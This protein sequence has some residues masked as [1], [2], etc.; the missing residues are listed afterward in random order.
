MLSINLDY[1]SNT[2]TVLHK[3]TTTIPEHYSL[4]IGAKMSYYT[5]NAK[6]TPRTHRTLENISGQDMLHSNV[7]LQRF[8]G[9]EFLIAYFFDQNKNPIQFDCS[10][11][12]ANAPS[13][14]PPFTSIRS[15]HIFRTRT[16]RPPDVCPEFAAS[17]L[18]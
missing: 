9:A 8:F 3:V 14:S 16:Y 18:C 11:E 10:T 5:A 7:Q 6:E 13:S 1:C 17:Q 12:G 15:T 4:V 2:Q